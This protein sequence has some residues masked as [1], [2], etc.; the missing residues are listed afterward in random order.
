MP[1]NILDTVRIDLIQRWLGQ[2]VVNSFHY[3]ISVLAGATDLQIVTAWWNSVK[4]DLAGCQ[5]LSLEYLRADFENVTQT[6]HPF[7]SYAMP[8]GDRN[9]IHAGTDAGPNVAFGFLNAVGTRLTK[10]GSFRLGGVVKESIAEGG[11]VTA[12]QLALN[13]TFAHTLAEGFHFGTLDAGYAGLIVYGAPH[14]ASQRYPARLV[15]VQNDS[16]DVVPSTIIT[17]QNTRKYGRGS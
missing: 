17:T 14:P 10:P 9:G 4:S 2:Q 1:T 16:T 6:D 11:F 12:S 7:A 15:G 8:E 5:S 3:Q 13:Q